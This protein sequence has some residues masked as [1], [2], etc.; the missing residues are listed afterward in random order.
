M[1]NT[2]LAQ[3]LHYNFKELAGDA[4]DFFF[5]L[6]LAKFHAVFIY[7]DQY[8][9]NYR[10]SSNS[11]S[12][13]SNAGYYSYIL[14]EELCLKDSAQIILQKKFLENRASVAILEALKIGKKEKAIEIYCSKHHRKMILSLGGVRRGMKIILS[15]IFEKLLWIRK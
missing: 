15:L 3:K 9:S 14:V 2:C 5:C 7:T 11:I 6:N 13:N 10:I 8:V 1:I 12:A 4:V